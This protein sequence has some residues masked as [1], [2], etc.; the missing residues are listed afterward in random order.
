[1]KNLLALV[2]L[3]AALLTPLAAKAADTGKDQIQ[4]AGTVLDEIM[5]IPEKGIPPSLLADAA[6]IAII[7]HVI[8]V[9]LVVGGRHGNGILLTRQTGGWS[10]PCFISL[11]GGSLGWQIGAQATDVIL[12]FK[13]RRSI[14]GVLQ[15][16]FTLG[17][18][19]SVAAGPVGR[20]LEGAT[21]ASLQA[22][23]FSYSRSRGLFAGVSLEGS[24]LKV[25]ET[26]NADYYHRP[27]IRGRDILAG[28]AGSTTPE[29]AALKA[30]LDR[31]VPG[32]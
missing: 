22:E 27:G 29:I 17:A 21:D 10:N 32:S 11:T 30:K 9:G 2:A 24:V 26:A 16:N 1:M 5:V 4:L 14:D 25:D 23:I 3:A 6:G 28:R 19:A 12:V 13:S 8:K 20:S 15:S 18:D 31:Y 7:P